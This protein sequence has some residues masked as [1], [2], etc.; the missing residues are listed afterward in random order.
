MAFIGNG[1]PRV[2]GYSRLSRYIRQIF[3]RTYSHEIIDIA[4]M[5]Y[6]DVNVYSTAVISRIC[7]WCVSVYVYIYHYS[8]IASW[9]FL[10]IFI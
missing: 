9:Q 1:K 6:V 7:L 5:S 8:Y 3:M 4:N 2:Y 10:F